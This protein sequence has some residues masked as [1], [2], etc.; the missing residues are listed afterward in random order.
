VCDKLRA[1]TGRSIVVLRSGKV[2]R[3]DTATCP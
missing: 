2:R 1:G 3:E